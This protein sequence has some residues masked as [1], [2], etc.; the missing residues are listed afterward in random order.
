MPKEACILQKNPKRLVA[1]E[2]WL[3]YFNDYLFQKQIISETE[4]NKMKN[5]IGQRMYAQRKALK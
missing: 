1:E 2:I 5:L 3:S 4:R